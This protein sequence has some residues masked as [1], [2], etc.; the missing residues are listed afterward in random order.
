MRIDVRDRG[1][2]VGF[3]ALVVAILIAGSAAVS[4]VVTRQRAA[5][6]ALEAASTPTAA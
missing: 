6:R 3:A 1:F 5:A 4:L 2:E